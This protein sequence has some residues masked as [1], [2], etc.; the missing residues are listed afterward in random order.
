[1]FFKAFT[2]SINI[3]NKSEVIN[4]KKQILIFGLIGKNIVIYLCNF[5]LFVFT[6][7]A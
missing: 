5:F 1:M 7:A 2:K 4:N 3:P 6:S